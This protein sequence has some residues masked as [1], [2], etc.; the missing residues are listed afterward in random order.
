M[1]LDELLKQ[2]EIKIP[3]DEPLFPLNIACRLLELPYWTVHEIL[4]EGIIQPKT[5]NKKK[6]LLSYRDMKILKYAKYLM[7]NKG[8]N[9]KGIKVI[10]EIEKEI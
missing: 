6:K 3:D 7:E 8:V 9:I 10:L 5:K 2:F 4:K 1:K